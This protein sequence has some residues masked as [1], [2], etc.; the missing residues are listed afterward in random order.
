MT[1]VSWATFHEG[2]S[3]A[4]Y[5]DVLLPRL[6]EEI[7]T[8]DGVCHSDVPSNPSV[9]LGVNGRSVDDVANEA[10]ANKNAFEIVFIHADTG[11]RALEA[12][13]ASR[14]DS[15]CASMNAVCEWPQ[16]RCVT[17]TPRHETEAWI[18]ADPH[19]VLDALGYRG[20]YIE[21]G[22]PANAA[23]AEKLVDPKATLAS[24]IGDVAGN[25]RRSSSVDNLF[26]AIARQQDFQMLRGSRSFLAFEQQLRVALASL[27]CIAPIVGT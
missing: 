18:L 17:V 11:G 22:L 4:L 27:G 2:N 9:R 25:R 23:E 19:A 6:I 3:D 16:A 12:N 10:C 13:L 7:I 15:Y 20:S 5:F 26:P 1:F 8:K 14:S 24:T 21:I